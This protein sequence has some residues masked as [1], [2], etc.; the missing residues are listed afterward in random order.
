MTCMD[1]PSSP[2]YVKLSDEVMRLEMPQQT[3]KFVKELRRAVYDRVFAASYAGETFELPKTFRP[4]SGQP[5]ERRTSTKR[6][7]E[8]VICNDDAYQRWYAD[9]AQR[10]YRLEH[11]SERTRRKR[12]RADTN[13]SA[14]L[15]MQDEELFREGVALTLE[16][17]KKKRDTGRQLASS[18]GFQPQASERPDRQKPGR[19]KGQT[20][21]RRAPSKKGTPL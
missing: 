11:P 21:A 14:E 20:K 4:R 10:L 17:L 16:R 18:G 15:L 12:K 6:V 2:R 7:I 8:M 9:V 3:D 5:D 19:A 13:P 1:T